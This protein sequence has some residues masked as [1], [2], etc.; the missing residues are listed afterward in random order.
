VR[1]GHG[2]L[3]VCALVTT[4]KS[5]HDI[6]RIRRDKQA[7]TMSIGVGKRTRSGLTSRRG[8]VPDVPD[9]APTQL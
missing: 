1:D 6:Y 5:A 9:A 4:T 7:R 8:A 2:Q 3:M